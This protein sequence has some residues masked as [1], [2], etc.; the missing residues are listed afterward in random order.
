MLTFDHFVPYQSSFSAKFIKCL[1]LSSF[2]SLIHISPQ[3]CNLKP[4]KA[5]RFAFTAIHINPFPV[6]KPA[7]N[8]GTLHHT[9]H[10]AEVHFVLS[11]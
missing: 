2:N 5:S 4:V 10:H 7:L 6:N 8:L 11:Q 1:H 3:L 9:A